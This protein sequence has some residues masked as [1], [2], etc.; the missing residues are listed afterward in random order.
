MGSFRREESGLMRHSFIVVTSGAN[1][2]MRQLRKTANSLLESSI[3][4]NHWI[5][6]ESTLDHERVTR[7]RKMRTSSI[8]IAR[9]SSRIRAMADGTNAG[10]STA[11]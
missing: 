5:I 1:C 2:T 6:S 4:P 9:A 3:V 8:V 7:T 10:L 11:R